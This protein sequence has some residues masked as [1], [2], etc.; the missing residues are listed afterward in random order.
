MAINS[1]N[2]PYESWKKLK[3]NSDYRSRETQNSAYVRQALSQ[4]RYLRS[5]NR[6]NQGPEYQTRA[7]MANNSEQNPHVYGAEDM[8]GWQRWTE[9]ATTV[10]QS[11]LAPGLYEKD[12]VGDAPGTLY[13]GPSR[14]PGWAGCSTCKRRRL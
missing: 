3:N 2:A 4:E 7:T 13:P 6:V 11:S 8:W 12:P 1:S 9:K 14:V 5:S 10:S